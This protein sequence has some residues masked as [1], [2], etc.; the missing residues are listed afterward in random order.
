M[1]PLP[2][3]VAVS[4]LF[5][6]RL[7]IPLAVIVLITWGLKRLDGRWQADAEARHVSEAVTLGQITALATKAPLAL[8]KPC[9]EY[10]NCSE[11]KRACCA[12]F[13]DSSLPC[14]MARLRSDGRLPGGCYGCA[15]FR[16]RPR[17]EPVTG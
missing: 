6:L 2:E 5:I 13:A 15:L 17:L 12:A 4:A 16:M 8:E 7:G 3:I 14:W 10:T 1:V 9:W 11:T